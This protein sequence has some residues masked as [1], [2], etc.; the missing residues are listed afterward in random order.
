MSHNFKWHIKSTYSTNT[1]KWKSFPLSLIITISICVT[2]W[3]PI[4]TFLILFNI[5][6]FLC[7]LITLSLI[8][9]YWG[10]YSTTYDFLRPPS[11]HI[12]HPKEVWKTPCSHCWMVCMNIL[13]KPVLLLELFLLIFLAHSTQSSLISWSR[14]CSIWM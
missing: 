10:L 4:L 11:T 6:R 12:T 14:N 8:I 3:I 2:S 7:I 5:Y 1:C 13:K 9:L